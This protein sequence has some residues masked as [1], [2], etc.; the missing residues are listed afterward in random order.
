MYR[1]IA[2]PLRKGGSERKQCQEALAEDYSESEYSKFI[3]IQVF[4]YR[5]LIGVQ[6]GHASQQLTL[7]DTRLALQRAI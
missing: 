3:N 6:A 1:E 7:T 5:F 4:L 2:Q